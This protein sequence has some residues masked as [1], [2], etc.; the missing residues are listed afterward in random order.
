MKTVLFVMFVLCASS[1]F[2]QA[3]ASASVSAQ[4]TIYS[5]ESHAEHASRQPLAKEQD[6]NGGVVFTY[7]QG[8]RPLWE[9]ATPTHEVPLGDSARMLRQEHSTAKKAAKC[10]QN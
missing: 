1:A 8:E 9:F 5:F 2:G 10:W 6:L 7:A 4:P 3:A